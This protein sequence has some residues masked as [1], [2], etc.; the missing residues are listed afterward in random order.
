M[1]QHQAPFQQAAIPSPAKRS[2]ASMESGSVTVSE[3]IDGIP[4]K[5]GLHQNTDGTAFSLI[6]GEHTYS[7]IA[8]DGKTRR[9]PP[10]DLSLQNPMPTP[11]L[12]ASEHL[13]LPG[14][15]SSART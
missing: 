4:R 15:Q 9:R 3:G 7:L 6:S 13:P 12:Q 10:K 11:A 5:P 1:H 2:I 14:T 8:N